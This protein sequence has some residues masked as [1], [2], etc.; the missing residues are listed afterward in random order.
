MIPPRSGPNVDSGASLSFWR[1][2]GLYNSADECEQAKEDLVRR[3]PQNREASDE[4]RTD[5]NIAV[6]DVLKIVEI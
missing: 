3:T 1:A 4:T 5:R 2:L 6:G